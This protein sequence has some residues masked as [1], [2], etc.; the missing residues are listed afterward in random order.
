M[1]RVIGYILVLALA[2]T[3]LAWVA[4]RPGGMVLD[5]G[6]YHVETSL[7]GAA[8]GVVLLTLVLG[9]LWSVLRF[10]LRIPSL[11]SYAMRA[12]RKTRGYDAITRGMIAVG[13]GDRRLARRAADDARRCL[14]HDP[15]ALLLDAQAAQ[16]A[17]DRPRAESAF[18]AMLATRET[19]LLGLR[20]LF[21][22]ASR[23]GD[24]AAALT[25]AKEAIAIAP[26]ALWAGEAV[27]QRLCAAGEWAEALATLERAQSVLD[28]DSYRR[29]RAVLLTANALHQGSS[30]ADAALEQARQ[31]LKLA[32]DLVPAAEI[33]GRALITR[34][35]LRKASRVLEAAWKLTPHPDLATL[36]LHV[37][38]G[39]SAHDRL[40]R[41]EKLFAL[42][43]DA[44]ESRL[45]LA[46]AALDAREFERVHSVLQPLLVARPTTRACLLM[47]ETEERQHG[48]SG[49]V[50]EWLSRASRAPRDEAWI[51]DGVISDHWAPIS[52]VSSQL[53]A[54]R[55]M[56]PNETLSRHD[57]WEHQ[58][59]PSA[60]APA[61]PEALE[62]PRAAPAAM[63]P[64]TATRTG[65]PRALA[66]VTPTPDPASSAA[67]PAPPRK[68]RDGQ[69]RPG[70]VIFPLSTSPD[71]PGPAHADPDHP[72]DPPRSGPRLTLM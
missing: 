25:H 15:L 17:G 47:A 66:P 23:R 60:S 11:F 5:I 2:A 27:L 13:A 8:V 28:R 72:E 44:M 51:A 67:P 24:A 7:L 22:E 34:G 43:P 53:D 29:Q 1:I 30:H 20:G 50:R 9:I 46:R 3:G 36:Y 59:S 19:K 31:A 16:M 12:R 21:V 39:D 41:A 14:G 33:V 48:D 45:I 56:R 68:T 49:H 38:A 58:P 35:D 37:R 63:G 62:P 42:R 69:D 61:D 10:V 4:D 65:T 64:S 26:G 70:D 52:P 6:A 18:R 32:P 71:D 40:A 57:D 54:F 55:W